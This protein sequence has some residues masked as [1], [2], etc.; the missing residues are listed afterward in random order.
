MQAAVMPGLA[1]AIGE[2][3]PASY[4]HHFA[5]INGIRMHYVEAGQGPLLILLHGF[6]LFWYSWRKQIAPLAAAGY[7]VVVP[8]QRGYGQT[9][10]PAAVTD[11]DITQLVG[12]V[13]GLIGALG[14]KSAILVGWDWGSA[15]AQYAALLRPDL[16][17][18]LAM[19]CVPYNPRGPQLPEKL[20]QSAFQDKIFYQQYFQEPGKAEREMDGDPRRILRSVF[21]SLSA[22]APPA[23]RW[24]FLLDAGETFT[25]LITDPAQPPSWL[26]EAALDHYAAEFTRSGF[27]GPLNW[28]RNINRLWEITS[29][30][31]GAKI[32]QAAIF[33]GGTEDF[34]NRLN[35]GAFDALESNVPRLK[36]KVLIAGAG[37]M[38]PEEQ[39]GQFNDLL[40]DFLRGM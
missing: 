37:H 15:V 18:A 26:S 3:D 23:E 34:G 12:D 21:Y 39:P 33:I 17:R 6:P 16:V 8:D 4:R 2:D 24:R 20:W 35:K 32:Q 25:D 40:L 38:V 28:Y 19:V 5:D 30:L 10:R 22:S 27:T 7:R 11:Y 9:S 29:F 1:S 36:N 14:E 13:V 31:A